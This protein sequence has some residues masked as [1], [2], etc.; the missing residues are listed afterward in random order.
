[1]SSFT[2]VNNFIN[3][4][5]HLFPVASLCI[6]LAFAAL[7]M[8]SYQVAWFFS[9][10][11]PGAVVLPIVIIELLAN[12]AYRP[13]FIGVLFFSVL[14]FP[15]WWVFPIVFAVQFRNLLKKKRDVM[16]PY[17]YVAAAIL[18]GLYFWTDFIG[19]GLMNN[20]L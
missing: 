6:F 4:Y 18:L 20:K 7:K 3:Q 15:A 8:W 2:A 12:P 19:K 14:V 5:F 17:S 11:V 10:S 9:L 16:T 13:S 1:M